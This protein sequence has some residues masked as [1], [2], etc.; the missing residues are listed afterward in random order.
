[1]E[2]RAIVLMTLRMVGLF[3]HRSSR[4]AFIGRFGFSFR[5]SLTHV[6][7]TQTPRRSP[8]GAHSYGPDTPADGPLADRGPSPNP[9]GPS[10]ASNVYKLKVLKVSSDLSGP[11]GP[12]PSAV[13]TQTVSRNAKGEP[14][15]VFPP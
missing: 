5:D 14:I 13:G 11:T 10:L 7:R 9:L 8:A 2:M 4:I 12:Y 6:T 15:G 3:V 1:M